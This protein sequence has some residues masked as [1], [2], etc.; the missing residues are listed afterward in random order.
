MREKKLL[1]EDSLEV[2][3][4]EVGS[5][6]NNV[7]L[8]RDLQ[9][10]ACV[11]IDAA[12][13]ERS[14]LGAVGKDRLMA[15]LLTHA[16]MDH[17]QAL[18]GVRKK[19]GAPVGIHPQEP[20]F[21]KLHPEI[22]LFDGQRIP[23]G[24]R[25]LEVLHT[26]GHTPGSVSFL[27]RPDFCFCGDTVFPGG[28]GKTWSPEDFQIL[29]QSLDRKIYTLPG[30]ITL[31]PGHGAEISVGNSREEYEGFRSQTRGKNLFGDVVWQSS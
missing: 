14:L 19:S 31:L 25:E 4:L 18:E 3:R 17:I 23:V 24:R 16:H 26:P 22:S 9:E 27:L 6:G 20:S 15:V 8:V 7:Y 5:F 29:L 12:A 28:P 13:E 1:E 30:D 10:K 11:L 2:L 21:A